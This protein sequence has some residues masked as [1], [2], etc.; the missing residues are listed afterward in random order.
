V[1]KEKEEGV[2][3]CRDVEVEREEKGDAMGEGGGGEQDRASETYVFYCMLQSM[4]IHCTTRRVRERREESGGQ[5]RK[6][7]GEV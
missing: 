7:E 3:T 4:H 5:T 2:G 6:R 1:K